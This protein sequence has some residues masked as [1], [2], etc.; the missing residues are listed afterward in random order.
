MGEKGAPCFPVDTGG[1][2]S[3]AMS[4]LGNELGLYLLIPECSVVSQ[5]GPGVE[6]GSPVLSRLKDYPCP[7]MCMWIVNFIFKIYLGIN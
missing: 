7:V 3:M 5:T 2:R 1:G 4:S 6:V